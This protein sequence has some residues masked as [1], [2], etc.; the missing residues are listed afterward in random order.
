MQLAALN[1]SLAF[2]NGFTTILQL[3]PPRSA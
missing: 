2:Y 1:P 3:K